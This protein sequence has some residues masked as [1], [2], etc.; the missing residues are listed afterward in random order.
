MRAVT[1]SR[2]GGT[3]VLEVSDLPEP[4][5]GPDEVLRQLLEG[6][7][8]FVEG[9]ASAPRRRPEDFAP[10]AYLYRL[11]LL[12]TVAAAFHYV[13]LASARRSAPAGP[14]QP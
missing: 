10:L 13:Y 5:P 14:D 9:K 11:T 1:F 7:T 12:L 2:F 4:R 6:N 3:E 8:R